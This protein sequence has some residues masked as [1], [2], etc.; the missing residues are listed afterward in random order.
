[1][2]KGDVKAGISAGVADNGYMTV[3]PASGEEWCILGVWYEGAVE[4]Y[5]TDG[6]NDIKFDSDTGAGYWV[7]RLPLTNTTYLKVKNVSGSAQ[8]MGYTGYQTK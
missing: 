2:A 3:Q 1:M 8:D 6:T 4:L 5:L 7:G